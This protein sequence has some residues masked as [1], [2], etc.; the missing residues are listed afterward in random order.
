[1]ARKE[2]VEIGLDD[3][4]RKKSVAVLNTVLSSSAVLYTKTRNYHWNVVGPQWHDLHELFEQQYEAIAVAMD[5]VAER[6]RSLGGKAVGT[7]GEFIQCSKIAEE[8]PNHFP[9]AHTMVRS[10]VD[11]H[12]A[13]RRHRPGPCY[14]PAAGIDD[15]WQHSCGEYRG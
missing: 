12:E 3:D 4:V 6:A 8:K 2:T 14:M 10:L 1:M 9:N 15:G 13:V 5:E 11:D 7:M